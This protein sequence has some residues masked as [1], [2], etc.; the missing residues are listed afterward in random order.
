MLETQE[1]AAITPGD[2]KSAKK[3]EKL[4]IDNL[5]N[6]FVANIDNPTRSELKLNRCADYQILDSNHEIVHMIIIS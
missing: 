6:H 5:I 1:N 3:N 4:N 2:S